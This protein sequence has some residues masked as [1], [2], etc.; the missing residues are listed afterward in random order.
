MGISKIAFNRNIVGRVSF[1]YYK[2]GKNCSKEEGWIR[3]DLKE[4]WKRRIRDT[5]K[6]IIMGHLK[7]FWKFKKELISKPY[8]YTSNVYM[9]LFLY[10]YFKKI[11]K[12]MYIDIKRE[13]MRWTNKDTTSTNGQSTQKSVL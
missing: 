5:R 7:L 1:R 2:Y 11:E 8:D 4:H 13:I 6:R 10:V 3:F 12:I 9:N